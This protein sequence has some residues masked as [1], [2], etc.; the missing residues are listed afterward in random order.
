MEIGRDCAKAWN[1]TI[2]DTDFHQITYPDGAQNPI[3]SPVK[4]GDK[5]WIGCNS[6]ILKGVTIG[7]N[8][9]IGANTLVNKDVPPNCLVVGNPMRIV[10]EGI[11]WKA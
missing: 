6:T 10:K 5:V 7:N 1:T 3:S 11:D 4:I 2:I 8:S 9:V